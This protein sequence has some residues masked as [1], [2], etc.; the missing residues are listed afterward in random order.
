LQASLYSKA[1]QFRDSKMKEV[2]N[3]DE[4][5]AQAQ[6]GVAVVPWCGSEDCGHLLED[7]VEAN[8]LGEPQYVSFP[9]TACSACGKMSS[10]RTYMARQY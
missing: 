5:K 8:M 1:Q 3:M 4:A 9:E 2:S 10:K 6:T 7:Q